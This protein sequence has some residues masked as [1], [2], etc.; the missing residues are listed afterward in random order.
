MLGLAAVP[1]IIQMIGMFGI[2]PESPR[3]L[4]QVS[5]T[6]KAEAVLKKIRGLDDVDQEIK[7]IE[8]S[9]A[10]ESGSWREILNPAIRPALFIGISLQ[11]FQQLCGINTGNS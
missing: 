11:A 5:Q 8:Q 4:M 9:I 3:W 7:E 6:Q 2:V 10:E 1:A